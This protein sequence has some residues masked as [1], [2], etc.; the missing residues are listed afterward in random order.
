MDNRNKEIVGFS[1]AMFLQCI[2]LFLGICGG[3]W[4]NKYIYILT[5]AFTMLICFT[6]NINNIYYHLL[7]SISF[8]VIYKL[9]PSATSLFA[10]IMIA[11]GIILMVRIRTFNGIRLLVICFFSVYLL[12]GMGSNYTTALKMVMGII[13]FYSFVNVIKPEDFKNHIMAFSLGVI[14]SSVIGTFRDSLPQLSAYFKTEYTVYD[15]AYVA[16]RFTGLY[17]DPNF[18][19]MSALF[20]IVLCVMLLMNKTGNKVFIWSL[21]VSLMV[22][23]FQS[24]SKMFLLSVTIIGVISIIYMMRSLKM[25]I[26][27]LISLLTLGAGI[28]TWLKQIG[29]MDIMF[30]RIFEGD[31]STGRFGIW[32]SYL[33]YLDGSPWTLCFGDGIGAKYLSVGGPHNTYIESI[34]FIGILGSIIY[35]FMIISI[36]KFKKY[37]SEKNIMNYLPLFVFLVTIGVLGCFTINELFFYCMLIWLGLNINVVG[38]C[39]YVKERMVKNVQCNSTN[40]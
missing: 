22:F 7:F 6:R 39:G 19:S 5:A 32:E 18:Y 8:T 3:V 31:I 26:V 20:A 23:G 40:L 1:R 35:L 36:F 12:M 29:Y 27:A 30:S 14:G 10:Y 2:I 34:F 9:D 15:R 21:L 28:I 13:L 24:Y 37:N 25:I 33:N 16:H 4:I 38:R 17:Y 11:V